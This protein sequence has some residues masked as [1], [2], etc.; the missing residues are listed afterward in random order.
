MP[1]SVL[2]RIPLDAPYW[3]PWKSR[4]PAPQQTV[5]SVHAFLNDHRP[6]LLPVNFVPQ[7]TL[8]DGMAYETYIY[9]TGSVPTRD[10]LHDYFNA[11]CWF[12]FPNTKTRLNRLQAAQIRQAGVGD[13]R[14]KTRDAITIID[15]N[16]FF[17]QC[18]DE[19]WQALQAKQW[20]TAFQALRPLWRQTRVIAFGHALLEKLVNPYKAITAHA[21]RIPNTLS[22][23]EI[24]TNQFNNNTHS[25]SQPNPDS[26]AIFSAEAIKQAD[27]YL[28]TFLTPETLQEKPFIPLQIFGIPGWHED[29]LNDDF[30]NDSKVFRTPK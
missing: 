1:I 29:Q 13:T 14:G 25:S 8:P 28:A 21:I 26:P 4:F 30:Y 17:I 22:L 20:R 5:P 24:P 3:S 7:E 10:G 27:E 19:L 18:P 12:T 23:P 15:E 16:G 11:L 9:E 2:N 6:A